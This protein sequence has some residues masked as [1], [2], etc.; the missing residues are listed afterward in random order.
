MK[1]W[2]FQDNTFLLFFI[3][4]IILA[5]F[6]IGILISFS[7]SSKRYL[8][9]K[10][11]IESESNSL[12]VYVI[13]VKK[14]EVIYFN[15]SN[16][17]N[18]KKIDLANFYDKFHPNDKEKIK[19]WIFSICVDPQNAE[20]YLEADAMLDKNRYPCFSLLKLIQYDSEKGLI[21][22]ENHIL[23]YITPTNELP[24]KK[25]NKNI[26]TGVVKRS[27]ME[28][29]ISKERSI[30]G[31]SFAIRFFYIKQKVL[32]NDKVERFMT[33]TLKNEIFPFIVSSS[34]PRQVTEISSSELV[35]FDL[36]IV[37]KDEAMQLANSIAHALNKCIA[38][39]G[40]GGSVNFAIGVVENAQFYQDFDSIVKHAQ[41]ACIAAQQSNQNILLYQKTT[42]P[43]LDFARYRD[44]IT[45]LMRGHK[46]R[47]LYR[48]IINVSNASVIGYFEYIRAYDSPFSNFVEI[49]QYAAKVEQ[50]RNILAYVARNVI[51]KFNTE[52]P[53]ARSKLFFS[54]SMLDIENISDVL[55]QIP[56]AK[57]TNI[58]IIFEEQEVNENGRNTDLLNESFARLHAEG[59]ELA[60]SLLDKNL[61]LHP[62]VYYNF[63]YFVA[64][65][66]MLAEIKK[67]NR[68]R[69]S[70]HTLIEQLLKYKK[71]IIATDLEGWKDIE[72]II[73]AGITYISSEA[74]AASNDMLLPVD[75]K[76]M[77]KLK[78]FGENYH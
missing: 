75:K 17:K 55:S 64:G 74:V 48:P 49:S 40:F 32:T 33:M 46:L 69:L 56:T 61:L 24:K 27:Q 31:F 53:E 26:I 44:N 28:Q 73:K 5:A 8:A 63:D 42:S 3:G 54:C 36:H 21:H 51:P 4:L 9:R 47:Y 22:M 76:K 2:D 10:K 35:L 58:V 50:N 71:P 20:E 19:N 1:W 34:T 67:N 16:I 29:Y 23:R 70:I 52:K 6:L 43:E 12:R 11:K 68:I 30:Y 13:N 39:N 77:D 38:L 62:S 18:K 15:R 37:T 57:A 59:Y 41:E 25:K 7:I 66:N 14:N 45:D 60:L 78:E 65:A 72:L